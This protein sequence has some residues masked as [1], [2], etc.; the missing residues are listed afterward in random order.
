ML[1]KLR[2]DAEIISQKELKPPSDDEGSSPTSK[3]KQKKK[4][5]PFIP[6]RITKKIFLGNWKCAVK[7]TELKRMK[8]THIIGVTE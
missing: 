2:Y 1:F 8:F 5:K 6:I 4:L 3:Q 7:R